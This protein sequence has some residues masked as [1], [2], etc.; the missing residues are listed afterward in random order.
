[1]SKAIEDVIA[2]RRRQ[3]EVEGH[4]TAHDDR[5]TKGELARAA[6]CYCAVAGNDEETRQVRLRMGWWPSTWPWD[7]LQ[8]K[9]QSRRRDLV[10]AGA[11]I[12]AEI[13]RLDRAK[14]TEA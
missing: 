7:W 8:W 1:M 5:H 12:I 11:L 4:T 2:E 13:E 10:R 6:A 3:I 14:E 9:P